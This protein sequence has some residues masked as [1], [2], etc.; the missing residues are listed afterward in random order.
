M[1]QKDRNYTHCDK[2][3]KKLNE[4]TF[5]IKASLPLSK[6]RKCLMRKLK[7]SLLHCSEQKPH[8]ALE[9]LQCG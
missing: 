3:E 2:K 8:V 4:N 5:I 1:R 9:H 6:E 7:H